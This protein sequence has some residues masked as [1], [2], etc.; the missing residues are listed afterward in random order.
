MKHPIPVIKSE[1]AARNCSLGN[2][3]QKANEKKTEQY[4]AR[5]SRNILIVHFCYVNFIYDTYDVIGNYDGSIWKSIFFCMK[6]ISYYGTSHH[7]IF[8]K[9]NSNIFNAYVAILV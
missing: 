9:I 4:T 3:T 2:P 1:K 6:S 5:F 7:K 8:D